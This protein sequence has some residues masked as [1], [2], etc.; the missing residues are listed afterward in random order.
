MITN[1]M[2][3]A[4]RITSVF[5]AFFVDKKDLGRQRSITSGYRPDAINEQTPGAAKNSN[6]KLCRAADIEDADGE[7]ANFCSAKLDLLKDIGLWMEDPF[8]TRTILAGES[9]KIP[10]GQQG[11]V[12]LQ[13]V[14]PKSGKRVFIPYPGGPP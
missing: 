3:L 10:F 6:H 2:D 4:A 11:W 13:S 12:H 8:Y 5:V 14:P 9:K 1:A 7:F